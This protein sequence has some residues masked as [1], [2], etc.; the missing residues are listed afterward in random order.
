M[1]LYW[2]SLITVARLVTVARAA[3]IVYVTDLEI[4]TYLAPCAASA[5]AD[6]IAQ[7]SYTTKCAE[8]ETALQSCVCS[9]TGELKEMSSSISSSVSWNCGS[10]A[11]DDFWSV[12]KVMDLYCDQ[13]QTITFS[14]PTKN[15]V[16][17]Y[18]TDIPEMTYLAPC[19]QSALSQAVL[20]A[21]YSR[22]PE[23]AEL[24]APCVCSKS[25]VVSDISETIKS[26]AKY[27]CDNNEDVTAAQNFYHEYCAM[28]NG[29]TSFAAP[30]GPPGDMTYYITALPRFK[31][32]H[33]CAQ[34]GIASAIMGQTSYLCGNGPQALASCICIKSGMFNYISTG[35][36]SQVKEFCDSTA[37]ADLSSALDVFDYYCS[38]AESKVVATIADKV[39]QSYAVATSSQ[40]PGSRSTGPA[41]TSS[42]NAA[43]TSNT[44]SPGND[45]DSDTTVGVAPIA[46]GV[47]G[48]VAVIALAVGIFFFIRRKRQ[49]QKRGQEIPST[50]IGSHFNGKPELMGSN[51]GT[52]HT[53]NSKMGSPYGSPAVLELPT[54]SSTP[55]PELDGGAKTLAAELPPSQA[56]TSELHAQSPIGYATPYGQQGGSPQELSSPAYGYQQAPRLNGQ[57]VYEFPAHPPPTRSPVGQQE[58]G[59]GSGP[60]EAY[61]LDSNIT[62]R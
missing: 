1:R 47:A 37:L 51:P 52:P 57:Q 20:G 50:H 23:A 41:Q 4:Y 40:T 44:G 22:C 18:I 26:S 42:R 31:S 46:G 27:S 14:S 29:T 38:A 28:N 17:A 19:A 6:N 48:G 61:E 7:E 53:G 9:N 33:K 56:P 10:S 8:D 39:T 25:D 49:Q 24:Q 35:L 55:R 13:D 54:P 62:R 30:A 21:A 5:I 15:I 2:F 45:G 3:D 11:S 32:L 12:F 43:G 16:K 36:T 34:S 59:W 60:V 58:M